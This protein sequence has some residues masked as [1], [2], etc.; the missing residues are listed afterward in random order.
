M[1]NV[2]TLYFLFIGILLATV[3]VVFISLL[4]FAAPYGRHTKKGF[5]LMMPARLSWVLMELP[6]VLCFL[7]FFL[8]TPNCGV[9]YIF[10]IMWEMH[11]I[12]RTFIFPFLLKH[13]KPIPVLI[14][15]MGAAFNFMNA[16]VNGFSVTQLNSY[17]IAWLYDPRFVIG[18]ILFISGFLIN[19]Q[20]DRILRHLRKP[21]ESEYKI[22]QGGLFQWVTCPNYLGEIIEWLGWAVAT[23]TL[24]GLLFAIWTIANL[25]PRALSHH[26]W[27]LEKFSDYPKNR[28]ALFFWII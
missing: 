1:M 16:Y 4:F 25:L 23:W 8:M 20:S 28:R 18:M 24:A 22:P 10:L 7:Y 21:N 12:N 19:L 3:S 27:Y 15:M 14:P 5:G 26:R 6:A 2:Y 13:P 11:Y 9:A 17:D